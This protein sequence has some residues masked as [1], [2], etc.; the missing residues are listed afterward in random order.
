MKKSLGHPRVLSLL[1]VTSLALSSCGR[2]TVNIDDEL[3]ELPPP[4]GEVVTEAPPVTGAVTAAPQPVT[5]VQEN[6]APEQLDSLLRR[7]AWYSYCETGS[8]FY[9]FY[10]GKYADSGVKINLADGVMTAFNYEVY[11]DN[12]NPENNTG[13]VS[14]DDEHTDDGYDE[15]EDYEEDTEDFEEEEDINEDGGEDTA[16]DGEDGEGSD[17]EDENS[18][19]EDRYGKNYKPDMVYIFHFG[20]NY[21]DTTVEAE[22]I[23]EN[24]IDFDINRTY[25]EHLE[26]YSDISYQQL[27]F[28]TN[29]ELAELAKHYYAYQI[30]RPNMAYVLTEHFTELPAMQLKIT[31]T[32]LTTDPKTEVTR[33]EVVAEYTVNRLNAQGYDSAGNAVDISQRGEE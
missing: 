17:V 9:C 25:T 31:L 26:F 8:T 28:Y 23:D 21:T 18:G 4:V 14:D 13:E 30:E 6:A 5:E 24:H 19:P 7:G 20:S 16:A 32:K 10:G 27:F 15:E 12:I 11:S 22:A 33:D 1:L 3:P 2:K 29:Q